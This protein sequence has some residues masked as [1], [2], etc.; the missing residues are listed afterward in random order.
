MSDALRVLMV[1]P[2][3]PP[4]GGMANQTRQ[5]MKLLQAEGLK[6]QLVQT[7]APYRPAWVERL[8]GVRA[9]FRLCPYLWQL[10]RD[11]RTANVV[12]VMA[13]SGWA[14]FL[15]AAPAVRIAAWS[16]VPVVV[17]YRGG[18]A[19]EFLARSARK[20]V[21]TLRKAQVVVPSKFLKEIFA[22]YGVQAQVVPNIVDRTVFYPADTLPDRAGGPH[23]MIARN[24]EHIY[25]ID[26]AI[27]ALAQ[28]SERLPGMRI[29][30]A[31]TGP[32][33]AA[34]QALCEQLGL[35]AQVRFVGRLEV[36]EMAALY[37]TADV[38]LN[39]SRVDNTPNSILE[40]LASGVP[41]VSTRAGGIPYLV[42]H[43]QTAWLVNVDAAEEI[44]EG[45]FTV[46]NDASLRRRL[47]EQG[48]QL[49]ATCDWQQVKMQWLTVYRTLAH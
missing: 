47:C 34:L 49:A 14:W 27:R 33:R 4:S 8:R 23:I 2:L 44:A 35:A 29:S 20:V 25:G 40:A 46:L 19:A 12:H 7:N 11:C 41:V 45:I 13:N 37:R 17:N 38:V 6:V 31:G 42:E 21:P 32:E 26:V 39:P 22:G 30:I 5:L 28:L 48:L 1:G 24:L 9:L 36:S 15:F 3:P 18:L 10:W 43:G 16:G